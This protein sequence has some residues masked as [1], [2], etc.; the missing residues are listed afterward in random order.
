M[1]VKLWRDKKEESML[2][3]HP[4]ISG[5]QC[6]AIQRNWVAYDHQGNRLGNLTASSEYVA[7][8]TAEDIFGEGMVARVVLV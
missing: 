8:Y 7:M 6:Q 5:V 2:P 3:R 1:A 4:H